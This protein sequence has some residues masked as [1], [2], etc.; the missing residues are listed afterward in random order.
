MYIGRCKSHTKS[1]TGVHFGI[2]PFGDVARLLSVGEDK[3][4]VEYDL[5]KST[6]IEGVKVKSAHRLGQTAVPTAMLWEQGDSLTPKYK[7]EQ[8]EFDTMIFATDKYKFLNFVTPDHTRD[9]TCIKTFLCPTYGGPINRMLLVPNFTEHHVK[10]GD[11]SHRLRLTKAK[12]NFLAY[13]TKQ[14]VVGLVYLP[15]DGNPNKNMGLIA[16]SGAVTSMV[17]SP[18]GKFMF[19]AGGEDCTM[20]Q[21]LI[22]GDILIQEAEKNNTIE[23]F[24]DLIEGGREGDFFSEIMQF[25]YYAQIRRYACAISLQYC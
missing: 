19:T 5:E 23:S 24:V 16:H 14:K 20:N 11:F 7:N 10:D 12:S 25:F 3:R 9:T 6:I 18:D 22:Q 13:S 2:V 15:I 4:L 21:W 1:I 17:I 8:R